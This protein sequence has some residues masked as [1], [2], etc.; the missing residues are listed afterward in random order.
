MEKIT[1]LNFEK[2]LKRVEKVLLLLAVNKSVNIND[3]K[4]S[5]DPL[6]LFQKVTVSKSRRRMKQRRYFLHYFR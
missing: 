3:C 1:G 4:V 6:L 2:K 5:V